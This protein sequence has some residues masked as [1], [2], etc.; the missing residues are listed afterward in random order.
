MYTSNYL[1]DE[2]ELFDNITKLFNVNDKMKEIFL[3]F[4]KL[5][6]FEKGERVETDDN[7]VFCLISG[8]LNLEDNS[9][10][11]C[12]IRRKGDLC[13]S[14]SFLKKIISHMKSNVS[15][16]GDTQKETYCIMIDMS[17]TDIESK[18]M[19]SKI[20]D[21]LKNSFFFK[22]IFQLFNDVKDVALSVAHGRHIQN[23]ILTRVAYP[24]QLERDIIN[25]YKPNAEKIRDKCYTHC[26]FQ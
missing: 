5:C 8:S 21:V 19:L 13:G 4:G 10:N 17:S 14:M 16:T 15:L 11:K 1:I 7:A 26:V 23:M 2:P 12:T 18:S 25:I 9:E 6:I 22:R 24:K 3:K 20:V